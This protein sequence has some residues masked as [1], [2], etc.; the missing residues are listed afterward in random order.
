MRR[1]DGKTPRPFVDTPPDPKCADCGDTKENRSRSLPFPDGK[2]LRKYS[3]GDYS[4]YPC[5]N[6]GSEPTPPEVIRQ[7]IMEA[8][9]LTG[10]ADRIF[11]VIKVAPQ[12]NETLRYVP[13]DKFGNVPA[14]SE[15]VHECKPT[16]T[17][18]ISCAGPNLQNQ[19]TAGANAMRCEL[20]EIFGRWPTGA[21]NIIHDVE[22]DDETD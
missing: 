8:R 9:G 3:D 10:A 13:E 1:L 16:L 4:C 12:T 5:A 6:G 20:D 17:G 18:R 7:G 19:R 21:I 15:Y 22:N 11:P 2:Y 14:H